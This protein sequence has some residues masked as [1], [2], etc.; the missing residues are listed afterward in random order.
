MLAGVRKAY[1]L[2]EDM[3][4]S[5]TTR[6]PIRGTPFPRTGMKKCRPSH[7]YRSLRAWWRPLLAGSSA[8]SSRR[9]SGGRRRSSTES[10]HIQGMTQA[11]YRT[12]VMPPSVSAVASSPW[13][14]ARRFQERGRGPPDPPG[15][16]GDD[17][18][19][20]GE[21]GEDD[22][23]MVI[24]AGD[25]PSSRGYRLLAIA[26]QSLETK[27]L[28]NSTWQCRRIW[29]RRTSSW[30]T[31]RVAARDSSRRIRP[32]VVS[33]WRGIRAS[34]CRVTTHPWSIPA[35]PPGIREDCRCPCRSPHLPEFPAEPPPAM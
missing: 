18:P 23:G 31:R 6:C 27:L 29:R 34:R 32:S 5:P 22:A 12:G 13:F 20:E 8:S 7:R 30:R 2:N 14:L 11:G 9:S 25:L 15:L 16:L 17:Q 26:C 35:W 4:T 33:A 21:C 1:G 19:R 10:T 3:L 28:E 24:A